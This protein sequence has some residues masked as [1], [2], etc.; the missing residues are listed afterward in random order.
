MPR[1][2]NV[3]KPHEKGKVEKGAIHY[4]RHNFWPL[5]S[6]GNLEDLQRQADHWRDHVANVRVHGTTG[7]KPIERFDPTR[8]RPLPQ[9]LPDCRDTAPGKVHTDYAVRFDGNFYTVPP[10]AI[11]KHVV[12]KANNYTLNIY[13]KDKP[14][15]THQRSYQRKMR[16]EQ[17]S[18][19]QE[20]GKYHRNFWRSHE[21]AAFI[22]LGEPAKK[23]LERLVDTNQPIKKNLK[24]LLAL[25]DEYGAYALIEA[26]ERATSHR[27]YG[28]HYIENILYQQ[29]TPQSTHHPVRLKN[30]H[31]NTIRLEQ[32]CLAEYDA[33]VIKRKKQP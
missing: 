14:I 2:T 29:M 27:A 30:N 7:K 24:K 11:T 21:S 9:H 10:W 23:Y 6:F 19:R 4:I 13:F 22:S 12:V 18:H 15:A 25:K 28:A 20:A 5:R 3:R 33:W 32:P 8:M 16:I 17:P 1:A 31:L 26:I